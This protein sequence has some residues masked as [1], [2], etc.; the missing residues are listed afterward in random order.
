MKK[1]VLRKGIKKTAS[2]SFNLKWKVKSWFF[3]LW[4][5]SS[6]VL[7]ILN[8]FPGICSL[9]P[10]TCLNCKPSWLNIIILTQPS[11][12]KACNKWVQRVRGETVCMEWQLNNQWALSHVYMESAGLYLCPPRCS[13]NSKNPWTRNM[14]SQRAAM[15]IRLVL[16]KLS[17]KADGHNLWLCHSVKASVDP[18]KSWQLDGQR[19]RAGKIWVPEC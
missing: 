7:T 18:D 8:R 17:Y 11:S 14:L 15:I 19:W 2:L 1:K 5:N 6:L 4:L 13:S 9:L 10:H 3:F 12:W 16:S